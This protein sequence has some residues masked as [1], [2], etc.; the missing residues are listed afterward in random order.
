[1]TSILA[2]ALALQISN[3]SGAPAATIRRAQDEVT[4]VYADIGVPIEWSDSAA[5]ADRSSAIQVVLLPYET[6]EL[7]H[8]DKQVMGAAV[9]TPGGATRRPA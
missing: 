4:R 6:G 8:S 1:M 2:A 9:R 7:R 5:V 3:L